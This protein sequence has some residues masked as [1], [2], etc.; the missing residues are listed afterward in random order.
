MSRPVVPSTPNGERLPTRDL[1]TLPLAHRLENQRTRGRPLTTA[2]RE[3]AHQDCSDDL[4]ID[5]MASG[6]VKRSSSDLRRPRI[7]EALSTH[8]PTPLDDTP[9]ESLERRTVNTSAPAPAAVSA[10]QASNSTTPCE[11]TPPPADYGP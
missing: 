11:P 3:P 10:R 2:T 5:P 8:P 4:M 9:K 7:R 1:A 6:T